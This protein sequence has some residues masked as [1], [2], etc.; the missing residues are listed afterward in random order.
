MG[1]PANVSLT[2]VVPVALLLAL[3]A[4]AAAQATASLSITGTAPHE[5]LIYTAGDSDDHSATATVLGGDLV[6]TDSETFPSVSIPSGCA[7]P[8][9]ATS[10]NCGP[11]A[12]FER[13]VFL[14]GWGDD[15]LDVGD[16]PIAVTVDGGGG[17]D[18]L[19]GGALGDDVTCGVGDDIVYYYDDDDI[20][21]ADCETIDPPYLDGGLRIVGDPHVGEALGLVLPTNL[22]DD[23]DEHLQWE[24]CDATGASCTD[25][26]G[27]QDLTYRL[28]TADLGSRIRARY[29][30]ENVLGYDTVESEATAI[31]TAALAAP[32][33]A[34]GPS[35][36]RPP[37]PLIGV[38]RPSVFATVGKAK[39][40]MHGHRPIL[41][42]G[43]AIGCPG[44]ASAACHVTASARLAGASARSLGRRSTVGSVNVPIAD[45]ARAR[46]FVPL[47]AK[48][49]RALRAR[50]KLTLSI[51]WRISRPVYGT[52]GGTF[53]ITVKMPAHKRR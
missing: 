4:P 10:V 23:G 22:G 30:V 41:D 31:V 1:G 25:I 48:A 47:N 24:R 17:D 43:R 27:A 14:F 46:L 2:R 37:G 5:T 15:D 29:G 13:V 44:L 53:T 9:G 32:P 40:I 36:T 52:V 42:T 8:T 39:L 19:A 33:P 21:D 3:A 6:I 26:A 38:P 34:F 7:P 35:T 28:T 50:Q 20:I 11:A 45:G 12:D 18:I 49:Y 51:T 16:L